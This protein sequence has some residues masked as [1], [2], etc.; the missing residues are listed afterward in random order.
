MKK[1]TNITLKDKQIIQKFLVRYNQFETE[2][3]LFQF[4]QEKYPFYIY[5]SFIY[6]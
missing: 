1:V 4:L 3:N 2:E 6:I 5:M